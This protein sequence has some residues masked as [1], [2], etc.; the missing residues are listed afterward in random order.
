VLPHSMLKPP[1][2]SIHSIA[3]LFKLRSHENQHE[4]AYALVRDSLE[5]ESQLTYGQLQRKVRSLA[6]RLDREVAPG[7]RALLL[8]PQGL[9]VVNAFWACVCA[10]LVPVP[11]P[12]PDPIRRNTV[13]LDFALSSTTPEYR[14]CSQPQTSR[15][16]CQS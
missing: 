11:A 2:T 15:P 10:G 16:K 9:D 1:P 6:G 4:L 12:A 13:F 3:D 8:Y 5:L 14:W 7:A